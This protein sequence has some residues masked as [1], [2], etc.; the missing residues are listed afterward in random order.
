[1]Q[2]VAPQAVVRCC[3]L[4]PG[5]CLDPSSMLH[6]IHCSP[7]H[8]WQAR[9]CCPGARSSASRPTGWR[10]RRWA[11]AWRRT[12]QV[13]MLL[14]S[15]A[16]HHAVATLSCPG[17]CLRVAPWILSKAQSRAADSCHAL[18]QMPPLLLIARPVDSPASLNRQL[19]PSADFKMAFDHFCLHAGGRGVVEGLSKQ[20][21]L[22][23]SKMAPSANTL[24]WCA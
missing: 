8:H 17:S 22:P 24:H 13:G 6:V 10:A 20:L 5:P 4:D 3:L 18:R 16:L 19:L 2:A 9:W 1:M 15:R 21:S 11:C 23:P 12:S 14:V 7:H